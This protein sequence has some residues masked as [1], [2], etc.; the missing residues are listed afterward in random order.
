MLINTPGLCN[1]QDVERQTLTAAKQML[2]RANCRVGKI[3]RA[4]SRTSRGR[5]ISQKPSSARCCEAAARSISSSAAGGRPLVRDSIPRTRRPNGDLKLDSAFYNEHGAPGREHGLRAPQSLTRSFGARRTTRTGHTPL[6]VAIGELNGDG[7][8]DLVTANLKRWVT[9]SVL[10]SRGDGTFR[11]K[12][13]YRVTGN[14]PDLSMS[15]SVNLNADGERDLATGGTAFLT[16]PTTLSL[17]IEQGRR[18]LPAQARL[19]NR[20]RL[21]LGRDR[22]PQRRQDAGPG[23]RELRPDEHVLRAPE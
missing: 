16:R 12:L 5:V 17:L 2:A 4:Y 9:V 15:R 7:K 8:P 22:R 13:D 19:S 10:T 1:V 20:I 18:Q 14:G 3:R 6:S 23:D 11:P 21:S